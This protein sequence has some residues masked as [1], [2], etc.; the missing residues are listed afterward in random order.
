MYAL[1]FS[2]IRHSIENVFLLHIFVNMIIN[3]F[4]LPTIMFYSNKY[5]IA[6]DYSTAKISIGL[7]ILFEIIVNLHKLK[8]VEPYAFK[9]RENAHSYIQMMV[10]KKIM[11]LNFNEHRHLKDNKLNETIS[12]AKWPLLTFVEMVLGNIISLF[13]FIGYSMWLSYISPLSMILYVVGISLI[14]IFCPPPIRGIDKKYEIWNRLQYLETENFTS[15]IHNRGDENIIEH[16]NCEVILERQDSKDRILQ[17][18]YVSKINM[19]F[20]II[21]GINLL[22]VLQSDTI[23]ES[24]FVLTYIQYTFSISNYVQIFGHLFRQYKNAKNEFSKLDDMLFKCSDRIIAKQIKAKTISINLSYTY[25]SSKNINESPF[26]IYTPQTINFT[27]GNIICLNGKS[28]HGKSTLMDIICGIIPW[29][30]LINP[31]LKIDN[32]ANNNGFE[33]LISDR[34]YAEQTQSICWSS[35]IFDIITGQWTHETDNND[36]NIIDFNS[37]LNNKQYIEQLVWTAIEM[38]ECTDFLKRNNDTCDNLKWIY[39]K[40]INPSGGQKVRIGIAKILY[41]LLKTKPSMIVLDEIDRA[42]QAD[43]AIKIMSTIYAYCRENKIICIISAHLTEVKN[44]NY[45]MMINCENG[46][47]TTV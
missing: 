34:V 44:M 1:V 45:D 31:I 22:I 25:P 40:N 32:E 30:Q 20:Y 46:V 24:I 33:S 36:H 14:I 9:F 42:V 29:N 4:I 13:P 38:A 19:M 37:Q 15:V 28:G 3:S 47:I 17:L 8:F 10:D 2:I 23:L 41:W 7:Y 16:V 35:C 18:T 6:N 11:N 21:F 27:P 26:T 43:M 39:T 5:I 12:K